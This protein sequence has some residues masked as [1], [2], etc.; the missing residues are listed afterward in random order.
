VIGILRA[1]I[2]FGIGGIATVLALAAVVWMSTEPTVA[3]RPDPRAQ[4][5][6]EIAQTPEPEPQTAIEQPTAPAPVDVTTPR[7]A[8]LAPMP[9]QSAL[10]GGPAGSIAP[11]AIGGLP[12]VGAELG[13][14]HTGEI[15]IGATPEPDEPDVA[16]KPLVRP[17]PRY[18]RAA[19]RSGVEGHVIVRM[20]ID[21]RGRVVDVAVVEGT[22][23]DVFDEVAL[24]T[25]R[26]YRFSPARRGGKAVAT[27][28]QQRIVFRLGR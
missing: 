4:V 12:I 5:V 8:G 28:V 7:S 20:R 23:P 3:P 14:G 15:E 27:T 22:P 11:S 10:V 2:A 13:T 9:K 18:P 17:S 26:T 25:A 1:A 24:Q 19:Q 21:E 16:A 6:Y